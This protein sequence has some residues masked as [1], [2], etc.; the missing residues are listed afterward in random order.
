MQKTTRILAALLALILANPTPAA[1]SALGP[2][3]PPSIQGVEDQGIY[4]TPQTVTVTDD[5]LAS[6]T[7]NGEVQPL[8]HPI[9][10]SEGGVYIITATDQA[11]NQSTVTA[12]IRNGHTWG[13]WESR[14][15]P[16][17]GTAGESVR[18]CAVCGVEEARAL[19]A[20]EHT[21]G[22]WVLEA[23][24]THIAPGSR[25]RACTLCG[26]VLEREEVPVQ[27][28]TY[29][30]VLVPPTA[31]QS[32]YTLHVCT[33]GDMYMD[34]FIPPLQTA[35]SGTVTVTITQPKEE[36]PAGE[37]ALPQDALP[38]YL[39]RNLREVFVGFSFYF[40]DGLQYIA[41]AG[42]RILFKSNP[43]AFYDT[44]G[45]W[46]RSVI[47]FAAQ[48]EL[49]LGT[50]TGCFSPDAPM[51]RAMF[52]TT[53]ARL[54]HARTAQYAASGFD[55]VLPGA[56]YFGAAAWAAESGI[57]SGTGARRFS[58]DAVITREEMAVMLFNAAAF[59][60]R[61]TAGRA[62]LSRFSDCSRVSPWAEDGVRWAVSFGLLYGGDGQ[63]LSPAAPATRAETCAILQRYIKNT[64]E[65]LR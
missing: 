20:Q 42:E 61:D 5:D 10:L 37:P 39:D 2:D 46:A 60:G 29:T 48:R 4:C 45:H 17:C 21:P 3:A 14:T 50:D 18:V 53:L 55:D 25:L 12:T 58:P 13:E 28:H 8:D 22:E 43:K 35:A 19:L 1:H 62:G 63:A 27:G 52:V 23:A 33:C 51:T 34:S 54:Y 26:E 9:P 30:T 57:V 32:G 11:G 7:V 41:P 49:L 47:S 36:A 64:L 59:S 65:S 56:Y 16:T 38:Y 40:E 24:P 6:V 31:T 44:D 15:N